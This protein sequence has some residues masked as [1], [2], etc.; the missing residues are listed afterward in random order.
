MASK[1]AL[2]LTLT[3]AEADQLL[4]YALHREREGWYYG[5]REHYDKRHESIVGKL[6]VALQITKPGRV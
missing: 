1:T 4:D 5:N 2:A 6:C 3:R